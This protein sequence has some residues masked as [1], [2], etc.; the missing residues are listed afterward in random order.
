MTHKNVSIVCLLA[1][2]IAA[3]TAR[4]DDQDQA[5]R[6]A[7][8]NIRAEYARQG[9]EHVRKSVG[10]E[11]K[12]DVIDVADKTQVLL[13]DDLIARTSQLEYKLGRVIKHPE[14]V[15]RAEK[16]W[17]SFETHGERCYL[18]GKPRVHRN[19][20]TGL[21]QMWYQG[22]ADS[23]LYATSEDGI[24]WEKPS[25]GIVEYEGS[26]DNNIIRVKVTGDAVAENTDLVD[27]YSRHLRGAGVVYDPHDP[28][29][30]RRYKTLMRSTG[31]YK[32]VAREEGADK[33]SFCYRA[34]YSPDGIHWTV[35]DQHR[36]MQASDDTASTIYD[37]LQ[38]QYVFYRRSWVG[39]A[40]AVGI[41]TSKD[42]VHWEPFSRDANCI[43][44][45]DAKDQQLAMEFGAIWKVI[46]G[47]K[48]FPYGGIY[49]GAPHVFT[50]TRPATWH[51]LPTSAL[52]TEDGWL[53]P[54][55]AWSRDTLHWHRAFQ[56]DA[57]IPLGAEESFDRAS[58][59][60]SA[61]PVRVGNEIWIYYDGRDGTHACMWYGEPARDPPEPMRGG[62]IGLARLRL[63]GWAL[64]EAGDETGELVTNSVSFQGS[65]L[66]INAD[67]TEGEIRVEIMDENEQPLKGFAGKDCIPV[68]GDSVRHEVNWDSNAKLATHAGTPVRLRLVMRNARL[69]SFQFT[70]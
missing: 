23:C 3:S 8:A 65:R 30:N 6:E 43:M 64:V 62:A 41:A 68:L 21:F 48:G 28:D 5:A 20:E 69:Y 12:Q 40:R 4:A 52:G 14:P 58:I 19:P 15:L 51:N 2:I 1:G 32:L 37:E 50:V 33:D 44:A 55:L 24:H 42:F 36:A 17:E 35:N 25:L 53:W 61:S 60:F 34:C 49:I 59:D 18:I 39:G 57:F 27:G 16:P 56:G 66:W 67:A 7:E 29:P 13:A 22:G 70:K 45:A 26:R 63:D 46:Y 9:P 31:T 38:N 10:P 11:V 54:E 47:F